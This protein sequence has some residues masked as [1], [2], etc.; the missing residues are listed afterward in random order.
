MPSMIHQPHRLTRQM[1]PRWPFNMAL[2]PWKAS[3][4]TTDS[5]SAI[6]PSRDRTLRRPPKNLASHLLLESMSNHTNGP[7]YFARV[8]SNNHRFDGI[9]GLAYDTI[10]VKHITPPFYSMI[11]QGLID[12]LVFSFRLGA[13]E[14]DGGEAVFGGI[15]DSAYTGNISYVPVHRKAYWEVELEEVSVGDNVLQLKNTAAAID[16]GNSIVTF[17]RIY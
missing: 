2:V 17:S 14:Q 15:D 9:L 5:L 1:E 16:T 4:P 8:Y 6:L 11:N 10:S 7:A 3:C 12:D 13:S